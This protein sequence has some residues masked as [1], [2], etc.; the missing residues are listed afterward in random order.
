MSASTSAQPLAHFRARI[1]VITFPYPRSYFALKVVTMEV[2]PQACQ[3]VITPFQ[4]PA[5]ENSDWCRGQA[6]DEVEDGER[7][8]EGKQV[9]AQFSWKQEHV[10]IR[11][12]GYA[13]ILL[14]ASAP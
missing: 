8:S 9:S 13:H 11:N 5:S 6:A 7:N 4:H 2:Q 1:H 12:T 3:R 10:A 14:S